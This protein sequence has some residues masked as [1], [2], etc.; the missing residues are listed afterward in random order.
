MP[1]NEVESA[2]IWRREWG[3]RR[4]GK[5]IPPRGGVQV[6]GAEILREIGSKV[7]LSIG[8]GSGWPKEFLDG[9]PE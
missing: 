1:N 7:S 2:P 9:W 5:T 4:V 3:R 6:P 8:S